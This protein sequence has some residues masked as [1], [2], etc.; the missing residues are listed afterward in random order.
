MSMRA[1]AV[2]VAFLCGGFSLA[3]S[4]TAAAAMLGLS[5]EQT[6]GGTVNYGVTNTPP[7]PGSGTYGNTF[8]SPTTPIPGAPGFGF[9][10][11]FVFTV[12]PTVVD[13]ITSTINLGDLLAINDLEVRL[14]SVIGNNLLPV[15]GTPAGGVIN[16][17][18]TAVNYSPGATGT[19][20]VLPGASLGAGTY[21][22]EV[23][24]NVV[25]VAGGGYSGVINLSPVP[26][27]AALPLLL[28]G[29]GLIGG[30]L[31]RRGGA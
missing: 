23:R 29:L 6:A 2:A 21:V 20:S 11:D 15:L 9:Y 30:A 28:C 10:D 17:W 16:A 7:V 19:V 4:G 18:S 14:Y 31:R 13:T 25:G 3:H 27:P 5:Y 1:K 22:L 8:T 26:L 12:A 24:G